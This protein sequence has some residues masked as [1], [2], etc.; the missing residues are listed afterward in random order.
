M[1]SRVVS[2]CVL[3][4]LQ[5]PRCI[6][7]LRLWEALLCICIC[8]SDLQ[9]RLQISNVECIWTMVWWGVPL[10]TFRGFAFV[11]GSNRGFYMHLYLLF[12][13]LKDVSSVSCIWTLVWWS[14]WTPRNFSGVRVCA[15]F[16]PFLLRSE[17]AGYVIGELLLSRVSSTTAI[18]DGISVKVGE[19]NDH[20]MNAARRPRL[21]EFLSSWDSSGGRFRTR[22]T[23]EARGRREPGGRVGG[24]GWRFN[25]RGRRRR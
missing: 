1:D 19:A 23:R 11:P 10:G 5:L 16:E 13:T 7:S 22:G 6:I 24:T 4:F 20:L 18:T 17:T 25:C 8:S 21:H 14:V 12:W 15:L 2:A 9:V 3:R